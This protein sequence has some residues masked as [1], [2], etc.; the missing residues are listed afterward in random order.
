MT[1]TNFMELT[2][3]NYV[4]SAI[5]Y[6]LN[7]SN[8]VWFLEAKKLVINI[9]EGELTGLTRLKF[10][11]GMNETQISREYFVQSK[12]TL[13]NV[14]FFI[15]FFIYSLHIPTLAPSTPSSPL[16]APPPFFLHFF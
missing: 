16:T 14:L 7:V 1:W 12:G 10:R 3:H 2:G 8:V 4:H 13:T 9:W 11:E 5:W 6:I 15:H